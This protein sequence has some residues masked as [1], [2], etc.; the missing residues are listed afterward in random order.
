VSQYGNSSGAGTIFKLTPDGL[1]TTLYSLCPEGGTC[2]DGVG[3]D[4]QLVA[5]SDG[6]LYGGTE[7]GGANGQGV[8]FKITL[9]GEF[10]TLFDISN[11]GAHNLL[12]DTN[13]DFYGTTPT[14]LFRL[15]LGLHPFIKTAPT[16][17]QG[18]STV[19]IL[20]TDLSGATAGTFDG[21]PAAFQ[22]VSSTEITAAVPEGASSGKIQVVTSTST[23]SSNL[24]F[25]VT[26]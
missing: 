18:G 10:T 19:E 7:Q 23:L 15:S 8:I 3:P 1:F 9:A 6:A 21:T 17:G 4:S 24:P 20:G 14:T 12:Q 5:G 2:P 11:G 26:P 25:T 16:F 22:V 13:G